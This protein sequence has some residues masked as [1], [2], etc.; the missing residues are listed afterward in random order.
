M[1]AFS[2][3]LP[4]DLTP[5]AIA[6]RRAAGAPP[7]DL[8]PTN[9][10]ECGIDYPRELLR[11][12]AHAAALRYRP[13][14]RGLEPAREAVAADYARHGVVV[15]PGRV[16]LTASTS[17]AY[18][19]LFKLLCDPGDA[20][21]VPHPSYPLF[22][23]LA[24]LD[25][26]RPV[27]YRLHAEAGWQPDAHELDAA[28]A[29]AVLA[30]HPNNPTGSLLDEASVTALAA[31]CR[32]HG[33]ALIA[34]EVFLDYPLDPRRRPATLAGRADLPGFVLGGLSKSVG[35]PQLKL[36]WIVVGGEPAFAREALERLE[37]IADQYLSVATPV[38]LALPELLAAGAVVRERILARC[39]LN[40]GALRAALAAAGGVSLVEPE[41]GWSAVLR[42][43]VVAAEEAFVLELLERDG[44][45][46]HPGTV[47][48]FPAEG[49]LVLSLLVDP[50]RFAA[51]VARLL[52]AVRR[53]AGDPTG[54]RP[55]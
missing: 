7:F 6:R 35:L 12:L 16:V 39:R 45:G 54:G 36:G 42:Y 17:E 2:H 43:P 10:T 23:H 11:P 51:G 40:L 30:V 8:T 53:K 49:Y 14:P 34:D 38:Q 1:M 29:R 55:A 33:R 50:Q 20:V 41:G 46:V 48:G 22:E 25:G 44:V 37:F 27:P 19:L 15:D 21:L 32:A 9:P 47:F 28:A 52:A 4:T 26:L 5:N 18:S 3:R 31:S 24:R 13:D